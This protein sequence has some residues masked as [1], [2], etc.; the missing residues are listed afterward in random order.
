[1]T[2]ERLIDIETKIAHQE[3]LLE[4]LSQVLY[5]QQKTIDHL[6]KRL[7]QLSKK[8]EDGPDGG[9]IGPANQKP[10]HY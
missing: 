2:E 3:H 9:D 5:E 7:I 8:I 6:E 10:P 4:E 1:M